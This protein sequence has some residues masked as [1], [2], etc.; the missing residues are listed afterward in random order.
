MA[1]VAREE[2][3]VDDEGTGV[4]VAHGVDEAHHPTGPAQVQPVERLAEGREVEEGVARQHAGS[5]H[6]PVVERALLRRRRVK[7]SQLS[8]AR[9]RGAAG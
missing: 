5:L 4:D 9:P 7:A 8:T 2:L 6:Q 1:D 3:T